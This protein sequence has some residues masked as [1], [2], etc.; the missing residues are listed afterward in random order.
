MQAGRTVHRSLPA[1]QHRKVVNERAK[2]TAGVAVCEDCVRSK[3]SGQ[4]SIVI[5]RS[6]NY[7]RHFFRSR[8]FQLNFYFLSFFIRF[9]R[10]YQLL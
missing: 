7:G 6:A 1:A 9:V 10:R 2:E 8:I 4:S 5:F 3:Q